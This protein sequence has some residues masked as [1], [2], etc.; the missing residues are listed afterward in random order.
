MKK[1]ILSLAVMMSLVNGTEYYKMGSDGGAVKISKE[2]YN[3]IEKDNKLP[4][5]KI[6]EDES[7]IIKGDGLFV[8]GARG[9]DSSE[10]TGA[11]KV[12]KDNEPTI[13]EVLGAILSLES[14]E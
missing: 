8:M 6:N 1:T 9:K 12:T 2:E 5:A 11:D 13:S 3:K 14:K 7:F 4:T 10:T